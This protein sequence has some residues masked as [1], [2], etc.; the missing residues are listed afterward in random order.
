MSVL[1]KIFDPLGQKVAVIERLIGKNIRPCRKG[2]QDEQNGNDPSAPVLQAAGPLQEQQR[3]G[4][5]ERQK[6]IHRNPHLL[7]SSE[8]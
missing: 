6:Q 5:F 3:Q 4:C 8:K 7:K 1:P 2:K